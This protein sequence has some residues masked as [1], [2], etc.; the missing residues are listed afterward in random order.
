MYP[1]Y[2][3]FIQI[4]TVCLLVVLWNFHQ[5][6]VATE[7]HHT[8][9][10]QV[11]DLLSDHATKKRCKEAKAKFEADASQEAEAQRR[12]G[13]QIATAVQVAVAAAMAE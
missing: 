9:Q 3:T 12:L 6:I 10:E 4:S 11:N 13:N 8:L 7:C 2:T 5:H 1:K